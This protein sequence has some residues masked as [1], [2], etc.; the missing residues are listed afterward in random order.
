MWFWALVLILLIS[1][2][3]ESEIE[4]VE[5]SADKFLLVSEEKN[6]KITELNNISEQVKTK[7]ED[8]IEKRN[9]LN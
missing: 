4:I 2:F 6:L 3:Q 1:E 8:L 9:E 7:L 5:N